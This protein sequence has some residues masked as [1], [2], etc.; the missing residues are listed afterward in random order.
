MRDELVQ[1]V[2]QGAVLSEI[3]QA[4][5]EALSAMSRPFHSTELARVQEILMRLCPS[6][7]IPAL[8]GEALTAAV[9]GEL[10]GEPE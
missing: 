9:I 3:G 5:S 6:H 10:R 4:C 2:G 7:R 1:I 8:V